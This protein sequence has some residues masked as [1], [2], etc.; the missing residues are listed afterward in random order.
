MITDTF[1][2]GLPNWIFYK[3]EILFQ[4]IANFVM[5]EV[6]QDLYY[7][8][9]SWRKKCYVKYTFKKKRKKNIV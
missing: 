6:I 1:Q 5:G 4:I 8:I 3:S 2:E 9:H 7:L